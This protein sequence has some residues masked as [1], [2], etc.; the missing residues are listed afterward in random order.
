MTTT[1]SKP[2][3]ADVLI[4]AGHEGRETGLTGSSSP[5]GEEK[6][7]TPIVA[8]KATSLLEEAGVTVIRENASLEGPYHVKIA[9]FLHFDGAE[10]KG[11]D[12]KKRFTCKTGA[13]VGYPLNDKNSKEAAKEWK[14][15]YTK[16][17]WNFKWMNDNFT[18]NLWKYYG[19]NKTVT[20][21]AKLVLELGEITCPEQAKWLK[22]RLKKLGGV[23]A[24]FVSKRISKGTTPSLDKFPLTI[25]SIYMPLDALRVAPRSVQSLD[26]K[27]IVF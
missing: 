9:L 1:I 6:K 18:R 4:Q 17:G 26:G 21:D 8:N 2:K 11:I 14:K 22:P 19:Y 25:P 10:Y 5:L 23:I 13:S 24:S 27:W 3:K 7:W 16:N 15:F 12:F 20:S